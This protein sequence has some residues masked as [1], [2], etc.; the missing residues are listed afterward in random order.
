MLFPFRLQNTTR[1]GCLHLSHE[2]LVRGLRF[3]ESTRNSQ[4]RSTRDQ[5]ITESGTSSM[6]NSNSKRTQG[7]RA[8]VPSPTR[9]A[10]RSCR[11]SSSAP[12]PLPPPAADSRGT[13]SERRHAGRRWHQSSLSHMMNST[14]QPKETERARYADAGNGDQPP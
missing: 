8:G 13:A 14:K 5:S 9:H 2:L 4:F 10:R 6:T 3:T 12:C 1:C 11:P 7:T